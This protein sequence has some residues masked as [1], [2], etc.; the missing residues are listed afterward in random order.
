MRNKN[1][2]LKIIEILNR[3]DPQKLMESGF[4]EDE[5]KIEADEIIKELPKCKSADEVQ[6]IIYN[7]FVQMFE[8]GSKS[9][10]SDKER[11]DK[12]AAG[13]KEDYKNIAREIYALK[14]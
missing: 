7:I 11:V 14:R 4:P 13:K 8:Y 6:N 5:Y 1:L 10:G 3:Y 2:E 9:D 12:G